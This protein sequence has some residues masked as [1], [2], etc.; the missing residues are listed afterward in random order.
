MSYLA[1]GSE[2]A[3]RP[4]RAVRAGYRSPMPFFEPLPELPEPEASQPTGWR[5]PLWDRPSEALV[6]AP[7]GAAV[8]L[9]KTD[10]V[11]LVLD[12]L[13]AYPNG[14]AFSLAILRNP[15]TPRPAGPG[16]VGFGHPHGVRG[17]RVGFE[18]S[19]GAQA[20]E[21]G[22]GYFG[23]FPPGGAVTQTLMA[24]SRSTAERE[25]RRRNPLVRRHPHRTGVDVTRRRGGGG[26]RYEMRFWCFPLPPPGPMTIFVEWADQGIDES[27]VA[28]DANMILDAVPQVVTLWE[29]KP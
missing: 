26:D 23:G 22:P 17:P 7:V 29:P 24:T 12:N 3:E 4:V 13:H 21:G 11:A 25:P 5:T 20:R 1:T 9:A 16:V 27:A 8:V 15:M 28:F 19:N 14:F 2:A 6:G 10:E 18:F